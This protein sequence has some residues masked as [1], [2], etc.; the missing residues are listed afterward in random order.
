MLSFQFVVS[1]IATLNGC[2]FCGENMKNKKKE[3]LRYCF[4]YRCKGCPR[5]K[6]CEQELNNVNKHR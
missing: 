2:F 6:K 4:R 5:E 3:D 1:N